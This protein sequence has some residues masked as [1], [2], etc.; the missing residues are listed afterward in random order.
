M[1][2]DEALPE[3][4]HYRKAEQEFCVQDAP[5]WG[6]L[7]VYSDNE[8]L[9]VHRWFRFKE[10]YSAELLSYA[11]LMCGSQLGPRV[12]L[13]DPF[14]GSGTTL[15]SGQMFVAPQID[16]IG[17]EQNPFMKFVSETKVSWPDL[18]ADSL[19][20]WAHWAIRRQ[21]T[22]TPEL[23]E[24]S[25]IAKGTCIS[26]YMAR[27]VLGLRE[28][29][30]GVPLPYSNV[31]RLGLAA[32][33]EALSKVR[34]DG[35]ALRIVERNTPALLSTVM[36]RWTQ[37]S[38]DVRL[39][40]ARFILDAV[41]RPQV[42]QGDGRNLGLQ[43]IESDSIDL[44]LTSPPYPNNIDYSEVYKLEL[45]L[46]GY[47]RNNVDFLK[48]RKQTFRSHPTSDLQTSVGILGCGCDSAKL[49]NILDIV[50]TRAAAAGQPWR[51]KL[52][53]GYFA[54][55][56]ASLAAQYRCLKPGARSFVVV[57]NSL[58]GGSEHA[59]LVPTDLLTAYIGS[60]LGFEVE[61]LIIA[62]NTK[63]RLAGNHFL[64]ETIVVLRKPYAC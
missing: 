8:Q 4:E 26:R 55:M 23:P 9:P 53:L 34:K 64:R 50:L 47:V 63:R 22:N 60:A 44:V 15:V 19:S 49:S 12:T 40:Q 1:I 3:L 2:R 32:S 42:K 6:R 14:C 16:A 28:V 59:Y 24:L 10:G 11:L 61:R 62:R 20:K 7:V 56:W 33:V 54:D 21:P 39:L 41:P 29:L 5:E 18:N 13:L 58:H 52:V 30:V 38:D 57:A 43:G 36:K 35:R 37:M 46:L 17:I 27:R 51:K 48:L 25:S 45:W 31:L